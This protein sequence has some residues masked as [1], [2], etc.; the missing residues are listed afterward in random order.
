MVDLEL[1]I[2]IPT[3]V[4]SASSKFGREQFSVGARGTTDTLILFLLLKLWKYL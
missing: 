3:L 2:A 1:H 4:I